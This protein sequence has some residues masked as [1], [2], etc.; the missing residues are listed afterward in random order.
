M[1][2]N[3]LFGAT[4]PLHQFIEEFQCC[5][6]V[7]PFR[8]NG[9]QHLTFVINGPPKI[10]PLAIY[11]HKDL[12]HVPL[13]F[14]ERARLLNT[15]PPY[16]SSKHRAKPVP[17]ISDSFVAHVDASLVQQIFDIPKR[18]R[19]TDVQHHRK[20]DD[21]G[22]GFEVFERGG[23]GDGQKLRNTPTPLTQSSSDKTLS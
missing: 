13:P 17:P 16:L 9:F 4:M 3:D 21:L 5:S 8:D 6:F 12:V 22:T 20:A 2:G 15:L 18:E 23:S 19:E 14:G 1:V 7:S 10:M 11:L